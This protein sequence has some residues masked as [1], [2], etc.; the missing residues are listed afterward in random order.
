MPFGLPGVITPVA[1]L[2]TLPENEVPLTVMQVNGP[3]LLKG[4]GPV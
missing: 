1:L 4:N 3:A 2:T